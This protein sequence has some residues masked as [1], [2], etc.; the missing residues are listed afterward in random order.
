MEW[1]HSENGEATQPDAVQFDYTCNTVYVRK[2]FA[3][4][5]AEEGDNPRPEHWSYKEI[6]IPL[7]DWE[8]WKQLMAHSEEITEAQDAA[9]ELAG[10]TADN[11]AMIEE[12]QAAIA[13]LGTLSA[14]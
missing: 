3:K 11:T 1:R 7:S 4:H 6:K 10:T 14:E 9:V 2:D 8:Y 12:L 13:E 5:D